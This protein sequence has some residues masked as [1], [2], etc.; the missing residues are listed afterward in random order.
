M[1]YPKNLLSDG[2]VVIHDLRPHWKA[3]VFPAAIFLATLFIGFYALASIDVS[4]VRVLI[5]IAMV[6]IILW[7]CLK[8]VLD[9]W[10]TNYV[11]T[12][13]R[14]IVRSGLFVR[15]G[16]DMPLSRINDVSFVHTPLERVLNSGSLFI[17]SGGTNGQLVIRNVPDVEAIQSEISR[18]RE[19]DDERRRGQFAAE[20]SS[21]ASPSTR[22]PAP[23]VTP[24]N[25][26]VSG[27]P[28]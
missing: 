3:L 9:W 12:D 26:D 16:R 13:R 17:E 18:L 14:V 2:E 6:L 5:G 8:P 20:G 7:F 24:G 4:Q 25:D 28:S 1:S 21:S 19:R 15:R 27:N 10:T 22:D 23:E 11:F